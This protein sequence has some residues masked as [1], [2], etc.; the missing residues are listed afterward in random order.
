MTGNPVSNL[1]NQLFLLDESLVPVVAEALSKV[2]YKFVAMAAAFGRKGVKDPEIVEWCRER[3]AV[4]VH[5]DDRARRQHKAQLQTSGIRTLWVYR[6]RGQM[7]GKEQLRIL[8]FVLPLLFQNWEQHPAARH[9]K[10]S[11]SSPL[12]KPTLRPFPV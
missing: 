6:K 7:T 12:A 10:A 5:A 4:W 8:A 2:D 11:A 1:S 3:Q 9:Y